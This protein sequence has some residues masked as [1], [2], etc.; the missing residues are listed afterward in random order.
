MRIS[1][2]IICSLKYLLIYNT[3]IAIETELNEGFVNREWCAD[4]VTDN[5]QQ[6]LMSS[7]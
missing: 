1:S 7:F 5:F 2:E 6:V 4:G 3:Q